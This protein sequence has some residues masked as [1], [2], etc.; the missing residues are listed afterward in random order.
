MVEAAVTVNQVKELKLPMIP[1]KPSDTRRKK[2]EEF[3]K[4]HGAY[5]TELEAIPP[6]KLLEIVDKEIELRVDKEG[7]ERWK[8]DAEEAARKVGELMEHIRSILETK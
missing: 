4:A 6:D 7:W 1:M 5:P 2:F 3:A 8:V